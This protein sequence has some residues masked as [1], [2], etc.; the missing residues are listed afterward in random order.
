M[1]SKLAPSIV[2]FIVSLLY[3]H[4]AQTAT[5]TKLYEVSVPVF[6]QSSRERKEATR[7]AFEEL[8]IRITGKRDILGM[9]ASQKLLARSRRYV[10]S[11]RYEM[12][13]PPVEIENEMATDETENSQTDAEVEEEK[14]Q[15]TQKIIVSFDEKAVK[16]SLWKNKLPVWGKTRP[17][18]LIWIAI[19]ENEQR[20]LLDASEVTPLL[21]LIKQQAER[22]GV[23]VV[24]PKLDQQDQEQVNVTDVWGGYKEPVFNA[25]QRY[26]PEA[27]IA[28]QFF[29]DQFGVWQT[30]WRMYQANEETLWQS[31]AP[32]LAAVV[33]EG[34]DK[35][36]SLLADRYAQVSGGEDS[37]KFLIHIS[38]VSNLADYDKIN[39]Y[40]TSLSVIKNADLAQIQSNELTYELELRSNAKALKQAIALGKTLAAQD[41]P[42]AAEIETNQLSYRLAP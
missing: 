31:S 13:P 3:F 33:N 1:L 24:Y 30:R 17:R 34:I 29:L 32:Q 36:A 38:D 40:L 10:R 20:M 23:P 8:L 21:E 41:D 14:P 7:K 11:F 42:F 9:E 2:F 4:T 39:R 27:V 26:A 12:L 15:P 28:A 5:L 37:N 22:R 16:N 18:T 6:S 25:S 19:S 35:L